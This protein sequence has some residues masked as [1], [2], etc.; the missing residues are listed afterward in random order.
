MNPSD[1]PGNPDISRFRSPGEKDIFLSEAESLLNKGVFHE[2]V[3]LARRRLNLFPGDI[4]ARMVCGRA[5]AG[6]GRT[7]ESQE[8]FEEIKKDILSWVRVFEYLGDVLL[9]RGEI[10]SA[11]SSYQ[12]L[13]QISPDTSATE[14]LQKK[15]DS[16]NEVESERVNGFIVDVSQDF[17]TMTMADLYIRQGHLDMARNVLKELVQSDP[18]NIRAVER[19]REVELLLEGKA[20]AS[21]DA[22]SKAI[23]LELERWLKKLER[24]QNH[25]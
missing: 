15:I 25:G 13:I 11:R 18:G 3:S 10:E 2:A 4:D 9:E 6:M 21:K 16:L 23:L 22:R 20:P 14:R 12:A 1:K 8:V 5:L 7:R 24:L 19:L 17:K